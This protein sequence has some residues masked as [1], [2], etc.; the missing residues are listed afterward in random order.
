MIDLAL[1][2]EDSSRLACQIELSDASEGLKVKL[3]R[4]AVL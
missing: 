2:V 1:E 3:A 4:D